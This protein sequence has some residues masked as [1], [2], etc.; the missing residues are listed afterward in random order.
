MKQKQIN[1]VAWLGLNFDDYPG[2]QLKI[3]LNANYYDH[4][5][6]MIMMFLKKI[7]PLYEYQLIC[8]LGIMFAVPRSMPLPIYYNSVKIRNSENTGK[9]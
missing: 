9:D 5:C 4:H 8:S 1:G 7:L 6:I 3:I 2:F